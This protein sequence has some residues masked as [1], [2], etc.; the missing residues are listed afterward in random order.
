[1]RDVEY[2]LRFASFYHS[3]Y[4]KYKPSMARFL[5]E[6]MLTYQ[7]ITNKQAETWACI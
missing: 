4:L 1:M 3:T 6:D 7:K 5:N 2:V